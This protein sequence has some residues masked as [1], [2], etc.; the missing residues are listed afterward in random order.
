[1]SFDAR[2]LII[3]IYV[4]TRARAGLIFKTCNLKDRPKK[5]AQKKPD[6]PHLTL[7]L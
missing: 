1:M 4:G 7:F 5:N 2:V 3:R 6:L